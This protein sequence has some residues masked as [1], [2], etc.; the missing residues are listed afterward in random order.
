MRMSPDG[1]ASPSPCGTPPCGADS[2]AGRPAPVITWAPGAAGI[3]AGAECAPA[4]TGPAA[5]P[6]GTPGARAGSPTCGVTGDNRSPGVTA[7][8]AG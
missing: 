2:S 1:P 6:T 8:A 5:A 3:A 4:G 7:V